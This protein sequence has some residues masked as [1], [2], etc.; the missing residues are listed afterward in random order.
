M[1]ISTYFE[2]LT[3]SDGDLHL[4]H[5][6]LFSPKTVPMASIIRALLRG[7]HHVYLNMMITYIVLS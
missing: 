1:H 4:I 2:T 5:I 6:E 7:L 3:Q